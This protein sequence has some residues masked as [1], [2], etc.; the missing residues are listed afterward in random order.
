MKIRILSVLLAVAVCVSAQKILPPATGCYIGCFASGG[1]ANFKTL[2]GKDLAIDMQ[3]F[4]FN[5]SFPSSFANTAVQN[6]SVPY[7]AW[8][9]WDGNMNGTTFSNQSIINGTHDTY[10]KTY[11]A[12]TKQFNKPL[13]IRFGHEMN[14]NWYSWDGT[15]SGGATTTGYGDQTKADGPERYVDAYKHVWQVFKD[16]GVTNVTW[17]WCPNCDAVPG[18][19]W[20]DMANYYPGDLYVDWVGLDG[21]NFGSVQGAWR[22]FSNI[23]TTPYSK[24]TKYK[25][26]ILI[27]EFASGE[28]GGDKVAWITDC[29]TLMKTTFPKIQAFAWFN[30]NKETD[31]RI[32]STPAAQAAFKTA[33]SDAYYLGKITL[34]GDLTSAVTRPYATRGR[35]AVPFAT[36]L[37]VDPGRGGIVARRAGERYLVSGKCV[38]NK[39]AKG[40]PNPDFLPAR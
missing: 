31:W 39:S 5:S 37:V 11:A 15:H 16:A 4:N 18:Q 10:L 22:M 6:G 38:E 13:F 3:F 28:S 30:I 1:A 35:S 24:A 23:Y 34:F 8:E 21:Y 17:I 40:T 14:G 32:N 9:P 26:P 33:M 19:A 12:A 36:V 7:I 20:N 25:K 27:G 2:T 29:F